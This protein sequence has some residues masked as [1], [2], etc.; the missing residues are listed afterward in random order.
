[1]DCVGGSVLVVVVTYLPEIEDFRQQILRY[2]FQDERFKVKVLTKADLFV[3]VKVSMVLILAMLLD[4]GNLV[5][6]LL[7][8]LLLL[9]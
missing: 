4:I 7:I 5:V 2:L 3:D 1:M 9:F 8:T 6:S